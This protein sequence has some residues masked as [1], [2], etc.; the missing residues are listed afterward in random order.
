MK[1][2]EQALMKGVQDVQTDVFEKW[3][4]F[5]RGMAWAGK[6]TKKNYGEKT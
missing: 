3:S 6:K 4:W 5:G 1:K 2:Q